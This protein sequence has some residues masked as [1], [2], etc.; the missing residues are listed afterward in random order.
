[1]SLAPDTSETVDLFLAYDDG[2]HFL[3]A[4][5]TVN[6]GTSGL[7]SVVDENT[8]EGVPGFTGIFTIVALIGAAS[9][10]RRKRD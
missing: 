9:L 4:E 2:V 6:L 10:N 5:I 3:A 8:G 7:P 1:M